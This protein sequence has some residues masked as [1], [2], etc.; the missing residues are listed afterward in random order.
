[1]VLS[2]P[3][4][5]SFIS[6]NAWSPILICIKICHGFMWLSSRFDKKNVKNISYWETHFFGNERTPLL[7]TFSAGGARRKLRT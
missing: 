4:N 6:A 3:E 5:E 1:M 7:P 2:V